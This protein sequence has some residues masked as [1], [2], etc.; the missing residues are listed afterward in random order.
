MAVFDGFSWDISVGRDKDSKPIECKQ[1]NILYGRNYSG[2][3]TLS[4]IFRAIE[5]KRLSDK[6]QQPEFGLEF[7]DGTSITQTN[8]QTSSQ[9]VRVFNEDFIR[10][11]L[12]FLN[13][14]DNDINAFAILGDSVGIEEKIKLIKSELGSNDEGEKTGL[15]ANHENAQKLWS[16]K[17]KA[18]STKET[19][20]DKLLSSKASGDRKNSIKYQSEKFGDQNYTVAKLNVD[21]KTV[22]EEQFT[23]LNDEQE[24]E[25]LSQLREQ[26]L[27]APTKISAPLVNLPAIEEQVKEL[28][29]RPIG[30]SE[31]I[32]QLVNDA[33]LNN[34]VKQGFSIHKEKNLKH[35]AF[36]DN[37]VSPNR[38]QALEKH[39]D[40]ESKK[41]EQDI[42]K[43]LTKIEDEKN[44]INRHPSFQ[45]SQFY[46]KYHTQLDALIEEVRNN[47]EA[48]LFA[49][50]KLEEQLLKRQKDILHVIDY[51]GDLINLEGFTRPFE[52][53]EMLCQESSAHTQQLG[54]QKKTAQEQ[55][56]LTEVYN[57]IQTINYGAQIKSIEELKT[58]KVDA[59]EAGKK[60]KQLVENK[61]FEIKQLEESRKDEKNGALKVNEYLNDYFGHQFLKLEPI[62]R[63]DG[64]GESTTK[65][66][67]FEIQRNGQ[68][69][70]HLSE[71]ECSLLAF[72]YFLAKLDDIETQGKKPIIW[73]DD[74]ISSLDSNHVFFVYSLINDKIVK[75]GVFE[76]LFISTHNLDFLKYTKR[77]VGQFTNHN[78][79]KQ[80]YEKAF[81]IIER[82]DKKSSIKLMPNY[83]KEYVTEFNYLFE[84]IYRCANTT[85]ITDENNMVCYN[86]GNNA[87]KFL[88]IY[89]YY[90]YPEIISDTEKLTRF[91]GDSIPALLSDRINNEYSHLAG[92]VERGSM[93]IEV[94]EMQTTAKLILE[95]IKKIPE[96]YESLC[97]SIGEQP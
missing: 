44:K 57:F 14:P 29:N 77:L 60:V 36:C 33:M 96:Q 27:L 74:P 37:E 78:A 91:F 79:K 59:E 18:H 55:L 13:N 76:Q 11:N 42:E 47:F 8:Y 52:N 66:V 97:R 84:Q 31:K 67:Y 39:F 34:W 75:A 62:E 6:Y 16:E 94:P 89:L 19:E 72:C 48:Y 9:I 95:K 68:K 65:Q 22:Q 4:R 1:L 38:W 43:C 46:T 70:Y 23:P 41:L 61:E 24:A 32:Q 58:A 30:Q 92:G 71:G 40:E 21:I 2:K 88:E 25:C 45:R 90:R 17:N 5:T 82:V 12:L 3:T 83:L 7:S 56:R 50:K 93:P 53:Y 86:F 20:L 15:Y 26:A 85:G 64:V 35:C 10:E 54:Q 73:I 28:L 81:F 69:A 49:L 80:D 63:N 51:Q 87:R